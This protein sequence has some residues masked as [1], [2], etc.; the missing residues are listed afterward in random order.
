[1]GLGYCA[2][3]HEAMGWEMPGYSGMQLVSKF[4]LAAEPHKGGIALL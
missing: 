3:V 2:Q 1:M 4:G